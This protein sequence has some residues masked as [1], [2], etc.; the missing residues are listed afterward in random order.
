M[1]HLYFTERG[2]VLM[3]HNEE[4]ARWR[5]AKK[6]LAL[7]PDA[8]HEP[9]ELWLMLARY[10]DNRQPLLVEVN[11]QNAIPLDPAQHG[12]DWNW[13]WWRL[14]LPAGTLREGMNEFTL[15][16]DNP[17]MN[18]WMLAIDNTTEHAQSFLSTDQSKTWQNKRLGAH[19]AL[20]GEYLM[21]LRLGD[22]A[23]DDALDPSR[24]SPPRVTY[25]DADH[26]R[27]REMLDM[28]PAEVRRQRDSWQQILALRTWVATQWTHDGKGPAYAPWDPWT[29]I[30]WAKRNGGHGRTGKVTMCVHFGVVFAALA[31]ALGHRARCVALTRAINGPEGH[32]VAEVFDPQAQCWILHDANC[33][34][35]YELADGRALNAVDI[36]DRVAKGENCTPLARTGPG[37]DNPAPHIAR[38]F[39]RNFATG[40]S[41][42]HIGIWPHNHY[43]SEPLVAPPNHGSTTYCETDFIWYVPDDELRRNTR[44][45]PHRHA[46]R[47]WFDHPPNA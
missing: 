15:K 29:V 42:R 14:A 28:L 9:A 21:R 27:V 36:A 38:A 39:E 12:D 37:M 30:D 26:S 5:W 22:E 40:Y 24:F 25:E 13:Y 6:Q 8:A 31:A 43:V 2:H 18:G 41:Y 4:L 3:H 44:M 33:D 10:P 7:P 47:D 35:H 23:S 17:A 16:A 45:F 20:R 46:E 1:S 11:G 19:G 34:A 32:F